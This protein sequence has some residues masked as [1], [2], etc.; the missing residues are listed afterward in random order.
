MYCDS[1]GLNFFPKQAICTRCGAAP[2]R[3][4]LQLMSL[5]TLL[6]AVLCNSFVACFVLPYRVS[7]PHPRFFFRAWMWLDLKAA[8][9]GWIPLALGLLAWDYFVWRAQ[10]PKVKGWVTRK[11]LTFVLATAIAPIIP[12]WVPAGQPPPNLLAALSR[13]PGLP[14]VLAWAVVLAVI[15]LLCCHAETRDS[16]LGHGRILS[17]VSFGALL[18]LLTLTLVGWSLT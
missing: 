3:H 18:L 15:T 5:V 8:L 16:L 7:A 13:H 9:Y 17:L 2:T 11:L 6:T 12:W 4:W 14:S 10:Q 1:C